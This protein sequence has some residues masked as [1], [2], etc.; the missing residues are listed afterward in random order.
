MD[1]MATAKRWR[2]AGGHTLG[3]VTR[4]GDGVRHLL[5]Y[6]HAVREREEVEVMAIVEGYVADVVCDVCGRVRTWVPGEEA[7]RRLLERGREG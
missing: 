1:E 6:R 7:M 2:C 3:V 4:D 5:L